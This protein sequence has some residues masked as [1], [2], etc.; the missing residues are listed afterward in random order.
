MRLFVNILIGDI[1]LKHS[2][3]PN[4]SVAL[5]TKLSASDLHRLLND[6]RRR[7]EFEVTFEG[8]ERRTKYVGVYPISVYFS[9]LYSSC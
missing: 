7:V 8:V 3:L 4:C 5:K 6:V 2:W 9:A 1:P